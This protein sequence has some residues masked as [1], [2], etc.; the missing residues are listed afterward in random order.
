ME[1]VISP[2]PA[3]V[4]RRLHPS[5]DTR[6]WGALGAWTYVGF[7]ACMVWSLAEFSAEAQGYRSG[8]AGFAALVFALALRSMHTSVVGSKRI[9]R[10]RA[11]DEARRNEHVSRVRNA[12]EEAMVPWSET[13][14]QTEAAWEDGLR[15]VARHADEQLAS[16][17]Q[18]IEQTD[19][20]HQEDAEHL[21]R[22]IELLEARLAGVEAGRSREET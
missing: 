12:V 15:T 1:D 13:V 2:K 10:L 4:T 20:K 9:A 6:D 14:R 19:N 5:F 18:Q 11:D 17:V 22:R 7:I 21:R 8:T 3:P 16:T